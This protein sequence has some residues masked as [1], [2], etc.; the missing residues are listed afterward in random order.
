MGPRLTVDEISLAISRVH[1]RR[2]AQQWHKLSA[3]LERRPPRSSSS[4]PT[5]TA[6]FDALIHIKELFDGSTM[7]FAPG[8]EGSKRS[9]DDEVNPGSTMSPAVSWRPMRCRGGA[10]G[11]L[12]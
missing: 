6:W 7:L 4:P 1:S 3:A 10:G 8:K 9:Q 5:L 11:R 2:S 12:S